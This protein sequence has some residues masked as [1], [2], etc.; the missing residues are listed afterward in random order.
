VGYTY[1]CSIVNYKKT[2]KKV[3]AKLPG[4]F[5]YVVRI[6]TFPKQNPDE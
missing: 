1:R 5:F 3:L 6:D 2:H 4:L